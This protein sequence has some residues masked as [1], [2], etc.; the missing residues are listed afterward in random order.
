VG[1]HG[2]I[3]RKNN[4]TAQAV[5][6]T[7]D[8]V[9]LLVT[10]PPTLSISKAIQL[11]KAGS[12]KWIREEFDDKSGFSWQRGYGAFSVSRGKFHQIID[13]IRL[14]EEH[15]QSK[16]FEEEFIQ[17]LQACDIEYDEKYVFG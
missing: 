10:I 2:G 1:I 12:S 13:Y 5:G 3:A 9:H 11:I 15:H 17:F 7:S 14:Q 8:H 16:E 6:G 4:I